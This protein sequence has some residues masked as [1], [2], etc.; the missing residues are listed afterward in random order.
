MRR[1]SKESD[2][3]DLGAEVDAASCDLASAHYALIAPTK[4]YKRALRRYR[5]A[6]FAYELEWA[7]A[8]AG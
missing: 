8:Q 7:R 1:K 4:T 3:R 2:L 5:M 6:K